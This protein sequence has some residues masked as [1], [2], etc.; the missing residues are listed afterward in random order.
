MIVAGLTRDE[1]RIVEFKQKIRPHCA[2]FGGSGSLKSTQIDS[3]LGTWPGAAVVW[4]PTFEHIFVS[5]PMR[6]RYGPVYTWNPTQRYPRQL[7]FARSVRLN[8]L[9]TIHPNSPDADGVSDTIAGSVV[10]KVDGHNRFWYDSPRGIQ[11]AFQLAVRLHGYRHQ[12]NLPYIARE[13]V[14]RNPYVVAKAILRITKNSAIRARLERLVNTKINSVLDFMQTLITESYFLTNDAYAKALSNADITIE[15]L[16]RQN[17]TLFI[18]APLD[19]I[20]IAGPV[21]KLLL[22]SLLAEVYGAGISGRQQTPL[23]VVLEELFQYGRDLGDILP[24]AL[25]ASRKFNT[26]L[27]LCLTTYSELTSMFPK[28]FATVLNNLG[29]TQWMDVG[30][31]PGSEH[32]SSMLGECDH[33][34][35]GKTLNAPVGWNID[36]FAGNQE[37]MRLT[38]VPSADEMARLSVSYQYQQ[39]KAPLLAAFQI[40]QEL[41]PDE[42]IVIMREA[43]RPMILKKAPWHKLAFLRRF[44]GRSPFK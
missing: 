40:R 25:A 7:S 29:M 4:D 3:T 39:T 23:L 26:T 19:Q 10:S 20:S 27:M 21:N 28:D 5:G 8:P 2:I 41:A 35:L 22:G 6:L 18:N 33:Y 12:Q 1:R 11:S 36:P 37:G 38:K 16:R 30:D 14:C 34:Q 15:S 9:H 44:A 24:A 31:I 32:L 13:I 17:G 42:Q 43:G